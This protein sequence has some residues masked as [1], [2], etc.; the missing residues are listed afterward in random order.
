MRATVS[1][2]ALSSCGTETSLGNQRISLE[3]GK[4]VALSVYYPI[5]SDACTG[6]YAV[7][8]SADTGKAGRNSTTASTPSATAYVEVQ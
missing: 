2:T 7:T 3:A 4:S 1:I 5:S 8:L 6:T